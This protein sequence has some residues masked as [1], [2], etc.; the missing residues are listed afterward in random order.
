MAGR[1]S[2]DLSVSPTVLRIAV[3]TECILHLCHPWG[4]KPSVIDKKRGA[5]DDELYVYFVFWQ[6]SSE[7]KPSRPVT[8]DLTVTIDTVPPPTVQDE[9]STDDSEYV[10][11]S[12]EN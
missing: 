12:E 5:D 10:D 4:A 9:G 7:A 2:H 11:P 6:E 3:L 8:G 1:P